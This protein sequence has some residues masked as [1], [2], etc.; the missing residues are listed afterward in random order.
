MGVYTKIHVPESTLPNRNPFPVN[1]NT[2]PPSTGSREDFSGS[3]YHY[4]IDKN[5]S[6]FDDSWDQLNPQI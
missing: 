1:L 4:D 3:A 2:H 6:Y 5:K